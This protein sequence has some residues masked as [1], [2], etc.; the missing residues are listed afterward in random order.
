MTDDEMREMNKQI[1]QERA[2]GLYDEGGIPLDPGDD[3][4][5]ETPDGNN[6][7]EKEIDAEESLKVINKTKSFK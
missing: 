6:D 4:D 5:Q 1:E 7:D 2:A 3:Q